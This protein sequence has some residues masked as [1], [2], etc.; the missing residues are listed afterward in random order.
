MGR[1]E[2][3]LVGSWSND[4]TD[5]WFIKYVSDSSPFI[6]CVDWATTS[7]ANTYLP[8]INATTLGA[9]RHAADRNIW[10]HGIKITFT[11]KLRANSLF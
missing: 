1:T 6:D 9:G 5:I 10:E 4:L 3:T 11:K 7:I 8:R 2:N